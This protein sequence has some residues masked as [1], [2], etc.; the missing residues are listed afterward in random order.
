[1][2]DYKFKNLNLK[3]FLISFFYITLIFFITHFLLYPY[4]L[5]S[6]FDSI[7]LIFPD[8][9]TNHFNAI[10][11]ANLL[12]EN[13]FSPLN[14]QEFDQIVKTVYNQNKS[15]LLYI[16]S[17]IYFYFAPHP[18][19]IIASNAIVHAIS[20]LLLYN[21]LLII[22]N[23]S[24]NSFLSTL[25]FIFFPTSFYWNLEILKDGYFILSLFLYLYS[26]L[27]LIEIIINK[28]YKNYIKKIP[29]IL[30]FNIFSIFIIYLFRN[31]Y[32]D[33]I[34][35]FKTLTFLFFLITILLRHNKNFKYLIFNSI[36]F[37]F[38]IFSYE[39]FFY[40][41]KKISS[42]LDNN[43]KIIM[44]DT[45]ESILID[46]NNS[47]I[48]ISNEKNKIDKKIDIKDKKNTDIETL[49]NV[50]DDLQI[51]DI[52]GWQKVE[53]LPANIDQLIYNISRSREGFNNL[54][55]SSRTSIDLDINF[56][57]ASSFFL[58]VPRAVQIGLFSPF[59]N[60]WFKKDANLKNENNLNVFLRSISSIETILIYL[61]FLLFLVSF[62]YINKNIYF[63]L[64][65]I[66]AFQ[67]MLIFSLIV[68]NVG[69]LI[70]MKY[71]FTMLIISLCILTVLNNLN[72]KKI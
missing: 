21:I 70:R 50:P 30:F 4:F 51:K 33:L 1:M 36:L 19:S 62:K 17:T 7:N 22:S 9:N 18:F 29:I 5:N 45:T 46:N 3:I 63:L 55:L 44:T 48:S 56:K 60:M 67:G 69:N 15:T 47:K 59:P 8:S 6:D 32:I 49:S 64:S 42:I 52:S 27:S 57:N 10:K 71:G 28:N 35:L 14:F 40:F 41:N 2:H 37:L 20:S 72:N 53:Y 26:I 39:L 68:T 12:K 24:N 16:V 25:P 13:N 23:N 66:F 11:V 31:Y 43:K 65:F 54:E 58:Y 34:L 61:I 38:V